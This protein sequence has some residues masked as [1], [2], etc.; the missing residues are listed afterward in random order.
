VNEVFIRPRG[1]FASDAAYAAQF[2][3]PLTLEQYRRAMAF[4]DLAEDR[5]P[6][7]RID[8]LLAAMTEPERERMIEAQEAARDRR[9]VLEHGPMPPLEITGAHVTLGEILRIIGDIEADQSI[10]V[11]NVLREPMTGRRIGV[12]FRLEH[13]T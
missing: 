3:E 10:R 13:R 11:E 4:G 12:A 7:S 6:E 9:I 5:T 1:S 8:G 2:S